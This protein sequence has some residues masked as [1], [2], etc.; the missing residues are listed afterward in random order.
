M[1]GVLSQVLHQVRQVFERLPPPS[2][3]KA[4]VAS[5]GSEPSS[6]SSMAAEADARL[7]HFKRVAWPRLK[8]AGGGGGQ[9]LYIP[10]YFDFVRQGRS[11]VASF[12]A[13]DDLACKRQWSSSLS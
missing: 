13:V 12:Q 3:A 7:E 8:E 11:V 2:A 9:L 1:Q 6:S 5:A 10:S 4:A